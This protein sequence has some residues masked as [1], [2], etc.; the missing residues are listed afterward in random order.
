MVKLGLKPFRDYM[1]LLM[2]ILGEWSA[3]YTLMQLIKTSPSFY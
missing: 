3:K 2:N 1:P